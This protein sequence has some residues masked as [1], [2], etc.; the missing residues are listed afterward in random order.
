MYLPLTPGS[1]ATCRI[2]FGWLMILCATLGFKA[3]V[4]HAASTADM[5][6]GLNSGSPDPVAAGAHITYTIVATNIGPSQATNPRVTNAIPAGATF[7]SESHPSAWTASTPA[8]GATGTIIWSLSGNL[9]KNSPQQFTL[10]VSVDCSLPDGSTITNTAST[11]SSNGDPTSANNSMTTTTTVN[12]PPPSFGATCLSDIAVHTGAGS[13]TCSSTASWT[14]PTATDTCGSMTLTADHNPGD[15]F[16]VGQTTVTYTATDAAGAQTICSFKVTVTD[17]T[18]PSINCG[19]VPAQ[20][21]D[22]DATS[23][24]A[25][26]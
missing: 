11:G 16:P 15:A 12:H 8:M 18:A 5:L 24:A 6:L 10:V 1:R 22:A 3:H 2:L 4:L 25:D 14:P 26:P 20:N 17:T 13:T 7:V 9:S 23:V 21:A 19:A